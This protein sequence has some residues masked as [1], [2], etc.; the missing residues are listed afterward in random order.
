[1]RDTFVPVVENESMRAT[2]L[3]R[4]AV[5]SRKWLEFEGGVIFGLFS[6][7]ESAR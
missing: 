5:L 7:T 4:R 3:A 2:I 6:Q 1:M